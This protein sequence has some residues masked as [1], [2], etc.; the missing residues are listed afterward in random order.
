MLIIF[1]SENE[2]YGS[3]YNSDITDKQDVFKKCVRKRAVLENKA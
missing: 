2:F 3:Q 1:R